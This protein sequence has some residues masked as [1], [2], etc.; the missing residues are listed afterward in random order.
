MAR[1][2]GAGQAP[3][4]HPSSKAVRASLERPFDGNNTGSVEEE[5]SESRQR[6]LERP[7]RA[8]PC[9]L[10]PRCLPAHALLLFLSF[11]SSIRPATALFYLSALVA[12]ILHFALDDGADEE[13]KC[14]EVGK[15]YG[16]HC[17]GIDLLLGMMMYG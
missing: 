4:L 12:S 10:L 5:S 13:G 15:E 7:V 2:H 16:R 9:A 14:T 3:A 8:R 17:I 1:G 6:H 11:A